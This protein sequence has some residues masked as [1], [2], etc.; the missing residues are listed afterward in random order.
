MQS[1]LSSAER[2]IERDLESSNGMIRL[3]HGKLN[4]SL[5]LA[6]EPFAICFEC[7]G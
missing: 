5:R 6:R 3:Q 7:S 2:H 1:R 4:G